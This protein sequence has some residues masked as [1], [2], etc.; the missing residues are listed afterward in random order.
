[1]TRTIGLIVNPVAGIGGSVGLK[2][3]DG[4]DTVREAVARG[5]V[6]RALTR[7]SQALS[8]FAKLGEQVELVT[9][10]VEMGETSA[11]AHGF[12]PTVVGSIEPGA[13]TGADTRAAASEMV[14]RGVD[15]LLFAGGDG[16]AA[17]VL[18][19]VG[20]RVTVLGIPAGVKM[21][22]GVFALT[23]RSAGRVA[24]TYLAGDLREFAD[25]EVMDL[26]EEALRVGVL[27][28]RLWGFLRIPREPF[29]VQEL[30][31]PSPAN[32]ETAQLAVARG[33]VRR[34]PQHALAI[35]G[36]GTTTA[37]LLRS[38]G[39]EPTLVGV[40]VV[41]DRTKVATDVDERILLELTAAEDVFVVVTP[42]G[43]QGFIFGRGNPQISAQVLRRV[44]RDNVI[45]AATESKLASLAGRPLL[46]D[47][48]D[49]DLDEALAG[50]VHVV[51]G[52]SSEAVYPV[53]TA[54]GRM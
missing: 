28:P 17:D 48:G 40:D 34:L 45:V 14:A 43:G 22:S 19:A 32:D 54:P 11:R 13:T 30:K 51:T 26:D 46:V 25:G 49:D 47:T 41:R 9:P 16:T 52:E 31:S 8:A 44:G 20:R 5:A 7:A 37:V 24:A 18:A 23:P 2:G 29:L 53:A 50:H 27:S 35:V 33:V 4:S 39:L 1:V 12:A 38:L 6:P 15:L 21:H 3:S 10:P 36:P 42:I